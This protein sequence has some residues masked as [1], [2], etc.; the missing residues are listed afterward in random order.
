VTEGQEAR[1]ACALTLYQL[2]ADVVAAQETLKRD[3]S[4]ENRQRVLCTA[5]VIA[6]SYAANLEEFRRLLMC[7]YDRPT[8]DHAETVAEWRRLFDWIVRQGVRPPILHDD[9]TGRLAP[10]PFDV[11]HASVRTAYRNVMVFRKEIGEK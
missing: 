9:G 1:K 3:K 2:A 11:V 8:F 10:L 6:E 5:G 4:D 7:K